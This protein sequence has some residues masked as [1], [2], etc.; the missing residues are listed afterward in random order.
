[1]YTLS[2]S[3]DTAAAAPH[4]HVNRQSQLLQKPPKRLRRNAITKSVS[5]I[6]HRIGNVGTEI[7][8]VS[9][10]ANVIGIGVRNIVPGI[11]CYTSD[12]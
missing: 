4:D 11:D 3:F 9:V 12:S 7:V 8:I 6:G 5:A 1:M 10:S 2:L